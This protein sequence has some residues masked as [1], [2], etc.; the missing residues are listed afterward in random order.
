[1]PGSVLFDIGDGIRSACANAFEDEVDLSK[2]F[3]N[4][5][6]TKSYLK[7]YVE[8][9]KDSLT[10]EE[11]SYIGLSIKTITYEL[12]LRFLTDYLSGDIYFK[13]KYPE[14]NKDRYKNQLT[15]LKDIESKLEEIDTFVSELTK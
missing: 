14:H 13:I 5:D 8:E 3:L 12:T 7:G 6:L 9:M 4:L 11:I 10:K 1:M 2:V 15:L